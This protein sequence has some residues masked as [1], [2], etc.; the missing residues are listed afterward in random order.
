[1]KF[2]KNPKGLEF[3]H[4]YTRNM[5]GIN[6]KTTTSKTIIFFDYYYYSRC[7]TK[8][9][10]IFQINKKNFSSSLIHET[11]LDWFFGLKDFGLCFCLLFVLNIYVLIWMSW[12]DAA[13]KRK[14]NYVAKNFPLIPLGFVLFCSSCFCWKFYEFFVF[15]IPTPLSNI[16]PFF[17]IALILIVCVENVLTWWWF[18]L[19][20]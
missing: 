5:T 16:I 14:E 19:L 12:F 9:K 20:W 11:R 15:V 13:R 1:M 6:S 18:L 4:I 17:Q 7:K 2:V 8:Q 3:S 10:K